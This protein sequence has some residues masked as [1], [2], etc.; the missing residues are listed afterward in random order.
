MGSRK[1]RALRGKDSFL[2]DFP[3]FP[4]G[5]PA[6]ARRRGRRYDGS[7]CDAS[8]FNHKDSRPMSMKEFASKAGN[9]LMFKKGHET[10]WIVPWGANGL[11]VRLS[12]QPEFLDLPQAL[13]DKPLSA[14]K[15]R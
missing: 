13:L 15:Q 8:V 12:V 9:G 5:Y 10:L 7:L 6:L 2:I 1:A 11:R 14:G 4:P 3:G